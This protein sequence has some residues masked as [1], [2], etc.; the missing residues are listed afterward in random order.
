MLQLF[1]GKGCWSQAVNDDM[2]EIDEDC[3]EKRTRGSKTKLTDLSAL[4]DTLEY[5]YAPADPSWPALWWS[6]D[7]QK[8]CGLKGG[9]RTGINVVRWPGVV[10]EERGL[11]LH[12]QLLD[13][14][15]AVF[16]LIKGADI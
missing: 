10:V 16:E 8:F 15:D 3:Y 5:S 4:V 2:G 13:I 6:M 7:P 11:T 9:C 1:M 12:R 14:F